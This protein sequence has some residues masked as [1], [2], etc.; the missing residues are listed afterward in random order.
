[1]ITPDCQALLLRKDKNCPLCR[2]PAS[3]S[4]LVAYVFC[5]KNY[6]K[7]L[8]LP[9]NPVSHEAYIVYKAFDSLVRVP[10]QHGINYVVKIL[11]IRLASDVV[12]RCLK[13]QGVKRLLKKLFPA[14]FAIP[15]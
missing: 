12:D 14:S 2:K 1:M 8:I 15:M 3:S 7:H 11:N 13:K 4:F 10:S 6:A 5:F 9:R